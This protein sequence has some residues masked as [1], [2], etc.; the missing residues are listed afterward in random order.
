[1][2]RIVKSTVGRRIEKRLCQRLRDFIEVDL[3]S[4]SPKDMAQSR[5]RQSLQRLFPPKDNGRQSKNYSAR[6]VLT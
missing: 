4:P 3:K 1:M 6:I 2:E 5:F